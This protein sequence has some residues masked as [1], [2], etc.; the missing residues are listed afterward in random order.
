MWFTLQRLY[1]EPSHASWCRSQMITTMQKYQV[2]IKQAVH[3]RIQQLIICRKTCPAGCHLVGIYN[4]TNTKH[5]RHVLVCPLKCKVSSQALQTCHFH[6]KTLWCV[7]CNIF[8]YY[9]FIIHNCVLSGVSSC[10][11]FMTNNKKSK[12]KGENIKYIYEWRYL[13]QSFM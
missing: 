8:D 6:C 7:E 4:S 12:T 9:K 2:K 3:M 1:F 5:D 11:I 10:L 13:K